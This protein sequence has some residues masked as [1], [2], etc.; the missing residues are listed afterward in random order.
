MYKFYIHGNEVVAVSTFAG[1]K[2]VGRA[3]CA[4]ADKF[5][6]NKGIELAAA[7]CNEKVARKRVLRAERKVKEA[8]QA[9]KQATEFY[10]KMLAYRTDSKVAYEDA[11]EAVNMLESSY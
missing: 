11:Q 10:E 1:K 3:K 9:L 5:D 4:P 8:E 2:V 7:R 6:E